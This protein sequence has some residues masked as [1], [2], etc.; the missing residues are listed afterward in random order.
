MLPFCSV[1]SNNKSFFS[2]IITVRIFAASSFGYTKKKE[3]S[4]C[5]DYPNLK[6]R[7]KNSQ[8]NK[9]EYFAGKQRDY[10]VLDHQTKKKA[11]LISYFFLLI[12]QHSILFSL[13][14]T[15]RF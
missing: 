14:T 12:V 8:S 15:S 2:T 9:Q 6:F 11:A 1:V 7:P 10:S 13:D 5:I 3:N 4:L